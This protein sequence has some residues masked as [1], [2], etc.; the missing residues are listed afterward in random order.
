MFIGQSLECQTE[1]LIDGGLSVNR[2]HF[3]E[4]SSLEQENPPFS[5]IM[6]PLVAK[7][8]GTSLRSKGCHIR[9]WAEEVSY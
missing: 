2:E 5:H 7:A 3:N 8:S 1:I 9:K 6:Q 4:A